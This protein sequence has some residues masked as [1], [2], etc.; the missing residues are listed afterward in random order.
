VVDL[1]DTSALSRQYSKVP[2]PESSPRV[3]ALKRLWAGGEPA[4]TRQTAPAS[5]AESE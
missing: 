2:R 5:G 4:A 3:Q 1:G